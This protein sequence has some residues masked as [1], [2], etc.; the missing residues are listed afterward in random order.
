MSWHRVNVNVATKIDT[1]SAEAFVNAVS[2]AIQATGSAESLN[3]AEVYRD[4]NPVSGHTSFYVSPKA[5]TI[6]KDVLAEFSAV[7]CAEPN[8]AAFRK[9][10][11]S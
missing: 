8:L 4:D 2:R 10:L 1:I 7:A 3:E 9:V 6:A 5:S 11:P